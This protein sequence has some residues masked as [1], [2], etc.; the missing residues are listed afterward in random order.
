MSPRTCGP[1]REFY[2]ATVQRQ[3]MWTNGATPL[4]TSAQTLLLHLTKL[5]S[6]D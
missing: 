4:R 2:L 6:P 5:Y 3:A 1:G